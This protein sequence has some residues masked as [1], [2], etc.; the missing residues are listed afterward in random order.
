MFAVFS[1]VPGSL[2]NPSTRHYFGPGGVRS[3]AIRVSV[4]LSVGL[5]V[6][7]IAYISRTTSEFRK[8]FCRPTCYVV[9][10]FSGDNTISYVLPVFMDDVILQIINQM[11]IQA[12][13]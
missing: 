3:I 11:Q 6:F 5:S 4:C 12:C 10:F 2:R 8:I 1:L 7:P 13:D 9:R